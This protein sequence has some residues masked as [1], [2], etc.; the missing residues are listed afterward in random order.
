M[1]LAWQTAAPTAPQSAAGVTK[2]SLT[3]VEPMFEGSTHTGVRSDAGC[4]VP[5]TP[6]GGSVLPFISAEGGVSPAR[7]MAAIATASWASW[8][9]ALYT[10]PHWKPWRT[11]IIPCSVASWP[12]V[13]TFFAATP[14]FLRTVMTALA[15]PSLAS[16]VALMFGWAVNCCWKMVPPV[17]FTQL[18]VIWSPTRV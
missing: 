10:E 9:T 7:R 1:L 16:T 6:W 5:E 11:L 17:A 18:G 3:T 4:E 15:R 8:Y 12:V 13:G 14:L 2:L